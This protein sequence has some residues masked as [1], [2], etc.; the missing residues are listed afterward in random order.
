MICAHACHS[1]GPSR[2]LDLACGTG[3]IAFGL[4]DCVAEVVAVDQELEAVEFGAHKARRLGVKN[5]QWITATAEHVSLR[6]C[7]PGRRGP[8]RGHGAPTFDLVAI[9]NAF[10]RLDRAVVADRVVGGL[11]DDGCLALLWADTPTSGDVPWQATL[12][13]IFVRWMDAAGSRDRLPAAWEETMARDPHEQVL[14]RAGLAYEGKF[15]FSVAAQWSIESIVGFMY[16]TSLLSRSALGNHADAFESDVQE[17]LLGCCPDGVF[18]QDLT[19][20]YEL[21]RHTG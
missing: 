7:T 16:S 21:A 19:F 11:S 10:H 13:E 15:D 8:Q 17:Q 14:R 1:I 18:E 3:Q 2:V 9:G 20:A 12:R 5:I 6:R 4:A